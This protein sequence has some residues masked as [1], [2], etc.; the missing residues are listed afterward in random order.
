ME[1]I[2]SWLTEKI[3]AA[4]LTDPLDCRLSAF[5]VPFTDHC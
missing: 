1:N 2:T 4:N 5:N 3:A